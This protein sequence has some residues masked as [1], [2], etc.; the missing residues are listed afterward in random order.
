VNGQALNIVDM[1]S[2]ADAQSRRARGSALSSIFQHR[3]KD[4]LTP[5]SLPPGHWSTVA[6]GKAD[7]VEGQA[8]EGKDW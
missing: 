1:I 8:L 2:E 5:Q 3:P 7:A 6:N 4:T